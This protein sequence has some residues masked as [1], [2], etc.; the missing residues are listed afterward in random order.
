MA[1]LIFAR[2]HPFRSRLADQNDKR[3]ISCVAFV[4]VPPGDQRSS[5]STQ[6]SGRDA[7]HVAERPLIDRRRIFV[8]ARVRRSRESA[9]QRNCVSD[10]RCLDA[11]GHL[12]FILQALG[13]LR[14]GRFIGI[15]RWWQPYATDPDALGRESCFLPTEPEETRD[16]QRAASQKSN[17]YPTLRS[18]KQPPNSMLTYT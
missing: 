6:I 4:K 11:G 9:P 18:G 2:K 12:Q 10:G 8:G 17:R 16:E 13:K 14:Q 7:V 15:A 5:E 1:N 3:T